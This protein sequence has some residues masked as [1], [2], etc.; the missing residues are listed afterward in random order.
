[1]TESEKYEL[2]K[3]SQID[4]VNERL[5]ALKEYMEDDDITEIMLNP[6]GYV[7]VESYEKGMY[8]T[9]TYLNEM[10]GYKIIQVLASYN[11][12]IISEKNP[13]LSGN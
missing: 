2:Q 4:F 11:S 9:S 8:K 7:W 10:E 6:D 5:S 12:K 1:M 3:Q 13:R